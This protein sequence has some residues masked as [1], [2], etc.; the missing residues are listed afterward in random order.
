M[1]GLQSRAALGVPRQR[2]HSRRGVTKQQ[3]PAAAA[4]DWEDGM[5]WGGVGAQE[6][7]G[8]ARPMLEL[9]FANSRYNDLLNFPPRSIFDTPPLEQQ[10]QPLLMPPAAIRSAGT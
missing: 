5:L 2:V 1:G 3:Q 7:T 6:W 4:A 8:R 9:T 10:P